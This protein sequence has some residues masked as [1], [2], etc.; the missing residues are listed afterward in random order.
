MTDFSYRFMLDVLKEIAADKPD[1]PALTMNGV[2]YSFAG[3]V[4][5]IGKRARFFAEHGVREGMVT[6]IYSDR[7]LDLS[8]SLLALWGLG[9]IYVPMHIAQKQE[10]LKQIETVVPPD[11]GFVTE[12]YRLDY[13]RTFPIHPLSATTEEEDVEWGDVHTPDPDQTALIMFTSGTSGVPKAVPWTYRSTWHNVR[14]TSDRLKITDQD[15]IF[16]NMP[17]HFT[18][19][20]IHMLTLLCRGGSFVAERGFLFGS[21]IFERIEA[22]N[23]TG[24][25]GV[26]VHFTRILGSLESQ[27]PPAGL[28]FLMNSGEHLPVPVLKQ[29]H[30]AMPEVEVYC[31][32]GLTEVSGRLCILD[33]EKVPEKAG[34]VGHPLAGLEVTVRD[35]AGKELP[36]GVEGEVHVQGLCLMD[37]Y[38]N[39]PETNA[40]VMKSY[41]FATGDFGYLDPD[42]DLFLKGRND[43]IIKVGGEKVSVKMIEDAVFGFEAFKEFMVAPVYDERMGTVP[44]LFYVLAPDAD[45]KRKTI[46]RHLKQKLP[47]T[48]LPSHYVELDKI[49]RASSGK[50][51]RKGMKLPD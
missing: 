34:S 26:P 47:A 48:H 21:A 30:Q 45:F 35:E 25:G 12:D 51:L 28:R 32:Y 3:L 8:L 20:I 10:K 49:P 13:R 50:A 9:A 24:F 7:D 1:A 17:L 41:G 29:I 11:I 37:G 19:S 23:C 31:V 4:K 42:G 15:R 14:Q 18:S 2:D 40:K 44:C 6:A 27:T 38:L 16:I 43:D 22:N 36:A 5:E 46:I 33:P 39:N